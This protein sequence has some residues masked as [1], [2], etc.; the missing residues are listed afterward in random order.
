MSDIEIDV[1][2]LEQDI[3]RATKRLET[4]ESKIQK[5]VLRKC[6][7]AAGNVMLK[8]LRNNSPVD[9]RDLKKTFA[10]QVRTESGKGVIASYSGQS[11]TKRRRRRA[12]HLHVV[13]Q[14]TKAHTI[15]GTFRGI[16]GKLR[17]GSF[18][19][20]GTTGHDFVDKT[21]REKRIQALQ[22]FAQKLGAEVDSEV[23]K[24]S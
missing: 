6:V 14:P 2:A 8:G 10:Q 9:D 12:A 24:L 22:A 1:A 3:R 20:P 16:D 18:W 7:R 19:H 11:K 13:D 5:R 21:A 23:S 17:E 4:V 15:V